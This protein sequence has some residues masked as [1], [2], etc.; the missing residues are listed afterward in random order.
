MAVT[1]LARQGLGGGDPSSLQCM[2]ELLQP[3]GHYARFMLKPD[4]THTSTQVLRVQLQIADTSCGTS[5][6]GLWLLF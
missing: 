4:R 2:A 1:A 5:Y 6:A 3:M